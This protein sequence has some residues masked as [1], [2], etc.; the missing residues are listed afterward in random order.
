MGFKHVKNINGGMAA[1]K[2][3]E[4]QTVIPRHQ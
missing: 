4:M 1:W 2:T 3:A